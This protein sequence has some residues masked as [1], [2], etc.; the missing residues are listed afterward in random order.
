[1][2]KLSHD[3]LFSRALPLAIADRLALADAYPRE[4]EHWKAARAEAEAMRKL[5]GRKL[6][7]LDAA[8]QK[9]AFA[10]FICAEQWEEGLAASM[11]TSDRK[12]AA[13]SSRNVRLFREARLTRWGRSEFEVMVENSETVGLVEFLDRKARE[14]RQG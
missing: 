12:V 5:E 7:Q 6:A 13:D 1:M 10:V 2:P 14:T 9:V 8:E 3:T 11:A 4:S